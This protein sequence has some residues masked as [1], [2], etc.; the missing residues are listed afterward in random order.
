MFATYFAP[1]GR[2]RLL[3]LGNAF[4]Q[5]HLK[6]DDRLIALL[7]DSGSGK[8]LLAKGMFPGLDLTNDD[9]GVH[10]RPLPIV[11]EHME[12]KFKRHSYHLDI[13]LE[14][15][16]TQLYILADAIKGALDAG[17]RVVVEHFEMV[18]EMVGR[19]AD[20]LIGIGEE[21][22]VTRPTIFGPLPEDITKLVYDTI[23]YRKK[24]HT[25]EII[26]CDLLEKN[27]GL[28]IIKSFGEVRRGFIIK[29][30]HNPNLDIDFLNQQV[31]KVISYNL[32]VTYKD[33]EHV[34]VGGEIIHSTGPRIHVSNTKQI[35]FFRILPDI[36]YDPV[37]KLYN[38]VGVVDEKRLESVNDINKFNLW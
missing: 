30:T 23:A 7:G 20:I 33:E 5:R 18:Y 19:N 24:A 31:N 17:K 36:I 29:L 9:E 26:T 10:I 38:L 11:E 3:E 6:P 12:G 34:S 27:Y 14:S 8:S 13:R 22:I 37:E 32:P 2:E 4:A 16:F 35:E 1:R 25:A 15:G 21:V 28:D